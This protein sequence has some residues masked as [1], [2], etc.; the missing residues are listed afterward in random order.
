MGVFDPLDHDEV[1]DALGR[2]GERRRRANTGRT[3][4]LITRIPAPSPGTTT[5]TS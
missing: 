4:N 3:W 2:V 1:A 5:A